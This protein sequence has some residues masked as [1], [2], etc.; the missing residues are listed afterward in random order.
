MPAGVR[1]RARPCRNSRHTSLSSSP[2]SKAVQH[3]PGSAFPAPGPAGPPDMRYRRSPLLTAR[4]STASPRGR[5]APP[6][7]FPA[8]R[9]PLP[10]RTRAA[11]AR[12]T[13][14]PPPGQN[15]MNAAFMPPEGSSSA[16]P[17]SRAS[18]G[19][20]SRE[21]GIG[22]SRLPCWSCGPGAPDPEAACRH[23]VITRTRP[24]CMVASCSPS[25]VAG[26]S[27]Q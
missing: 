1:S 22:Y 17:R 20:A 6:A 12:R 15:V 7:R 26:A 16:M 13:P 18:P 3:S 5:P 24:Y 9:P 2:L 23:S 4:R 8:R 19:R 27:M 14:A 10:L 25:D 11:P 21:R